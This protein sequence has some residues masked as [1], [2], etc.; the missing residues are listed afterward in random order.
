[1]LQE[2]HG[3]RIPALEVFFIVPKKL[4]FQTKTWKV[5]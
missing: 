3:I 4:K 2:L 1:M 5:G